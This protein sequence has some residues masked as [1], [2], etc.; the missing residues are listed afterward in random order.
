MAI[1]ARR[2]VREP[3][4][5]QHIGKARR[6]IAALPGGA[7]QRL[8]R[9]VALT[10]IEVEVVDAVLGG[11]EASAGVGGI[12][13]SER[14]DHQRT[15]RSAIRARNR[16]SPAGIPN[17]LPIVIE[18]IVGIGRTEHDACRLHR[19]TRCGT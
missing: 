7:Q 17:A 1:G 19:S 16:G 11:V 9:L 4:L 3:P 18:L 10:V 6:K 13:L 15:Q 8:D 12:G 2:R 14:H 5:D